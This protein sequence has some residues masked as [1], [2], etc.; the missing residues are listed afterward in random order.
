ML[1]LETGMHTAA[2]IRIGVDAAQRYLVIGSEYGDRS[3]RADFDPSG[4]LVT[5]SYDSFVRLYDRSFRLRVRYQVG[6]GRTL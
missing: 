6:S 2:I 5:T 4:W 1:R 3:N